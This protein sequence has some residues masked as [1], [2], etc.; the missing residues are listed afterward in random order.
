LS[1]RGAPVADGSGA[2]AGPEGPGDSPAAKIR[3]WAKI[4]EW[5]RDPE[6]KIPRKTAIRS[7][8]LRVV[9]NL[10][11]MF[12]RKILPGPGAGITLMP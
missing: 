5:L 10:F 12:M 3:H 9:N 8:R 7:K 4:A 11:T 1:W 6:T 2:L